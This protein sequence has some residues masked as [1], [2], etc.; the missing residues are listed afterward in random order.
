MHPDGN[1]L[2]PLYP[3]NQP[4][5]SRQQP[6]SNVGTPGNPGNLGT[7]GSPRKSR[8]PLVITLSVIGALVVA[9]GI[10]TPFIIG[11]VQ[12]SQAEQEYSDTVERLDTARTELAAALQSSTAAVETAHTVKGELPSDRVE[13]PVIF[14]LVE[15]E[16]A[17]MDAAVANMGERATAAIGTS[18]SEE[19]DTRADEDPSAS[20]TP[21]HPAA[22]TATPETT[23]ELRAATQELQHELEL[24]RADLEE[25]NRLEGHLW[26]TQVAVIES[27][28]HRGDQ[29]LAEAAEKAGA[30]EIAALQAAVDAMLPDQLVQGETDLGALVAE[31]NAAWDAVQASMTPVWED[32]AGRWCDTGSPLHAAGD[33]TDIVV[34]DDGT[35]VFAFSEM[36]E[37]CFRGTVR[38]NGPSGPGTGPGANVMYCPAGTPTPATLSGS[39]NGEPMVH[40]DDATRDRVWIYHAPG[41][42]TWFRE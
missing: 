15:N 12:H 21:D 1:S 34:G 20:H 24:V 31:F 26:D 7:P 38:S 11:Q 27:A 17:R 39:F 9:A 40:N 37:Q 8:K 28:K 6:V 5:Q 19:H 2:P 42:G 41:S 16:L 13:D 29:L 32:V 4:L 33:C 23:E 3:S 25:I 35:R 10:A 22:S 36:E 14:E 18:T 30:D